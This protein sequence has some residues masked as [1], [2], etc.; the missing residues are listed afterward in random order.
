MLSP[1]RILH[2]EALALLYGLVAAVVWQLFTGQIN[3]QGI[4]QRKDGSGETSPERVQLLLATLA[5]AARY[6][7][8]VAQSHNGTLP[9]IPTNWLYLMGGSSSF[10]ALHKMWNI[11]KA[12]KH[13][14]G[15]P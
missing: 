4:L 3:L 6:V 9:D 2:I 8:E 5:A 11:S 13:R 15:K 10:Y 14:G 1:T 7:A 12:A